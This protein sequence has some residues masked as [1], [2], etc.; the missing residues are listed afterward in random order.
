MSALF[1]II[2]LP[3]A[4][5]MWLS[6]PLFRQILNGGEIR[7][8]DFVPVSVSFAVLTAASV[9]IITFV[10]LEGKKKIEKEKFSRRLTAVLKVNHTIV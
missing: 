3:G 1:G 8:A 7:D 9:A 4:A 2:S 6:Q 10:A 5:L